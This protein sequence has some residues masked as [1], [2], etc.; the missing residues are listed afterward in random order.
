MIEPF[1]YANSRDR[2][3]DYTLIGCSIIENYIAGA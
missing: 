2:G 1:A 3:Q